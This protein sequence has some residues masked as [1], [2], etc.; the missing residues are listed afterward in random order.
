MIR[1][2]GGHQKAGIGIPDHERRSTRTGFSGSCSCTGSSRLRSQDNPAAIEWKSEVDDSILADE[3]LNQYPFVTHH[4]PVGP[5]VNE[6]AKQQH[7]E[8]QN[9]P[10]GEAILWIGVLQ[11]I[12]RK[13]GKAANEKNWKEPR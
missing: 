11:G 9:D 13:D 5:I 10:S 8:H 4:Q 12:D 7:S 2:R 1:R 3:G 6:H